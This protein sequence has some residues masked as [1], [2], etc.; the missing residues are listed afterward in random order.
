[1]HSTP[2]AQRH[3]RRRTQDAPANLAGDTPEA[4]AAARASELARLY[5]RLLERARAAGPA[6]FWAL[7]EAG[8][9]PGAAGV[10]W[11]ALQVGRA[12]GWR[13]GEATA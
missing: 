13:E 11:L 9:Q 6:A 4:A 10:E 2:A 7:G 1:M 8:G 5:D 3:C 12:G